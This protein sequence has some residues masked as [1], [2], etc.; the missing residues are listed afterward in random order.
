MNS[1]INE[2]RTYAMRAWTTSFSIMYIDEHEDEIEKYFDSKIDSPNKSNFMNCWL[3]GWGDIDWLKGSSYEDA[4][5]HLIETC[6][7]AR[8][9]IL[10]TAVEYYMKSEFKDVKKGYN[11]VESICDAY[12][13]RC[14]VNH[15]EMHVLEMLNGLRGD[16]VHKITK[17]QKISCPETTFSILMQNV[18]LVGLYGQRALVFGD[19]KDFNVIKRAEDIARRFPKV[20]DP[21]SYT[22]MVGRFV[23]VLHKEVVDCI[24]AYDLVKHL[25][26]SCGKH[27]V[28]KRYTPI[29]YEEISPRFRRTHPPIEK[30]SCDP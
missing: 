17:R 8:I 11:R 28:R 27:H 4:V 14:H 26:E 15:E 13:L 7:M 24:E 20:T 16:V 21:E 19:R 2:F 23:D 1:S 3:I 6:M 5:D 9:S 29:H 18:A 30:W 12:E 10:K 22:L 25:S